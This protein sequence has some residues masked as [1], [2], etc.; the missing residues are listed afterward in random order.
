MASRASGRAGSPSAAG[1]SRVAST[2]GRRWSATSCRRSA[3]SRA[4]SRRPSITTDSCG[5]AGCASGTSTSCAGSAG[6]GGSRSMA[7]GR[8]GT[9]LVRANG[10]RRT[11]WS[12][13]RDRPG[14]P[15][16]RRPRTPG[17]R[18]SCS[19]R[20]G[21]CPLCRGS[22]CWPG[23]W[24]SAGMTAWSRH[25][26]TMPRTRSRHA[27]WWPPPDRMT[28][29]RSS[30]AL[31]GPVSWPRGW[32][33]TWSIATASC[34]AATSCSSEKARSWRLQRATSGGPA[35][36]SCTAPSR[37]PRSSRSEADAACR[38]PM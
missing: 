33:Q 6:G 15:R 26:E 32:L 20:I 13:G 23:S 18:S 37:P 16:R 21:R 9:R 10:S 3:S 12:W 11:C 19:T 4:G 36:R 8:R 17:R 29:C 34:P 5:R 25:W 14:S 1:S 28:G 27:P 35:R 30:R 7:D 38:A 31:T 24:P 22:R 2:P